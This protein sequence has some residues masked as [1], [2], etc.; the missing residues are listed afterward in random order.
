MEYPERDGG[1]DA[2]VE[3]FSDW[4]ALGVA[5]VMPKPGRLTARPAT[6]GGVT[7][8]ARDAA[9]PEVRMA[10]IEVV[11]LLPTTTEVLG[12]FHARE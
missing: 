11:A 5:G 3:I 2:E 1:V 4:L 6:I 10:E 8:Q 7:E 9:V 12:G